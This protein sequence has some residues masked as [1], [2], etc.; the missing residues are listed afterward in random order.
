MFW[1]S[2]GTMFVDVLEDLFC[3]GTPWVCAFAVEQMQRNRT[4]SSGIDNANALTDRGRFLLLGL[5]GERVELTGQIALF[6]PSPLPKRTSSIFGIYHVVCKPSIRALR[7][8]MVEKMTDG[9]SHLS[10][11]TRSFAVHSDV[12]EAQAEKKWGFHEEF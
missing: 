6:M 2:V 1:F 4:R 3:L 8:G 9:S 10:L 11:P 7:G 5:T 12:H